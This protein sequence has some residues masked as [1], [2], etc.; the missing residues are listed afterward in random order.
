MKT[1]KQTLLMTERASRSDKMRLSKRRRSSASIEAVEYNVPKT[2]RM[3][4][5]DRELLLH[6][7]AMNGTSDEDEDPVR[8][9]RHTPAKDAGLRDNI[10]PKKRSAGHYERQTSAKFGQETTRHNL[11][12]FSKP[13]PRN[14]SCRGD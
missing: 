2:K 8:M 7:V 14:A 5:Q 10:T 11:L 1:L 9:V 13:S 4:K 6:T 3:R 12:C